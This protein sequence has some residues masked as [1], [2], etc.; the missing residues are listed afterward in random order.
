VKKETD[1]F[2]VSADELEYLKQLF[3]HDESL[4]AMLTFQ[5][6]APSRTV[7]IRLSRDEA[8]QLRDF[9]TTQLAAVGFDKN[10][11]PNEQGQMLEE[12]IDRFYVP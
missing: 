9:L 1:E 2:Q 12:L 11:S 3:S 10:Y 7:T 6:V 5:E 4:A 8:E